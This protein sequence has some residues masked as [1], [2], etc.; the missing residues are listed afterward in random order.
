MYIGTQ[1]EPLLDSYDKRRRSDIKIT[2]EQL[3]PTK[4]PSTPKKRL[5]SCAFSFQSVKPM[6]L[7]SQWQMIQIP[8]LSK[9]IY[10]EEHVWDRLSLLPDK[11]STTFRGRMM[12]DISVPPG[13][14]KSV[15]TTSSQAPRRLTMSMASSPS[16]S[17]YQ[18]TQKLPAVSRGT[19]Q[20]HQRT[21]SSSSST[22][23]TGTRPYR[24][25]ID[26]SLRNL[27]QDIKGN[28]AVQPSH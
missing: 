1:T 3:R 11:S 16:T 8:G 21:E 22:S 15:M 7:P 6:F 18:S 26:G 2:S 23:M 9:G 19:N 17:I 13:A 5:P 25:I 28:V 12:A 27:E 14:C 20:T 4:P 24:P 10:P